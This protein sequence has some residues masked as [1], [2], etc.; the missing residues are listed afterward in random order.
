MPDAFTPNGECDERNTAFRGGRTRIV[1]R[2]D[3]D[4][5]RGVERRSV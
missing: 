1:P 3:P 2:P 4:Y 5:R